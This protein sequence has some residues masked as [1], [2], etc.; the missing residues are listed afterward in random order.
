MEKRF[1]TNGYSKDENRPLPTR[2][3]KKVIGM[4]KDEFGGKTI[5][6][7]VA[8]RAKM[9]AYKKIDFKVEEK[10]C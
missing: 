1:G 2:K 8:L 9:Y 5:I 10:R 6:E 7:F 4:L 3:S